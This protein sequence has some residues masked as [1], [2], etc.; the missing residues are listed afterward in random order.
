MNNELRTLKQDNELMTLADLAELTGFS[1]RTVSRKLKNKEL[2]PPAVGKVHSRTK[3]LWSKNAV[4][5]FIDRQQTI[6]IK[7]MERAR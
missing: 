7:A 2:P 5:E 4:L 1:V 6:R 3:T